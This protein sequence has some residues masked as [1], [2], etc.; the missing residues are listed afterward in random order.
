MSDPQPTYLAAPSRS[1][2]RLP[3]GACDTHVHVF[4]PG[5]VFP[6]APEA[7]APPA[8]APK[9][10]LFALHEFL[11]IK[12]CVIVQSNYHKMDN[13]AAAD[14]IAAKNG[15][16]AGVALAPYDASDAVLK[17]LD[18]QGFCGIRFNFMKHLGAGAPID[19]VIALTKRLANI[20]WHLQVHFDP[21]LIDD[22]APHFKQ[23]AVPVVIDHMG[24]VD[25]SK[26][27]DQP[28]F[29]SLLKL[30]ED[31]KFRV[32]VSGSER[33]SQIGPPYADAVPFAAKL[34][35]EFPDQCF[36][37]LDWPHPN[38]KH[39]PIPDDGVLTDLLAEIAPTEIALK[40]L[41]VDNPLGFY[42]FGSV[43][44]GQAS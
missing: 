1:K 10:K 25:A 29:K 16:Y 5:A 19:G 32:K 6:Y 12:H 18:A 21:E 9:E 38:I 34:M 24:R 43:K 41:M 39:G 7:G 30:M 27:L 31:P 44:K 40:K 8:D 33:A 11:G 42:R 28:T 20:G 35:A 26:G 2:V 36:W 13:R 22:Y 37:G 14:A 3:A 17:A 23:S 15:D 4:G